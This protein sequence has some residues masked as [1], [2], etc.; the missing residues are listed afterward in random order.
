MSKIA[1]S[2][3]FSPQKHKRRIDWPFR[4][5]LKQF[6]TQISC[7]LGQKRTRFYPTLNFLVKSSQISDHSE[8]DNFCFKLGQDPPGTLCGHFQ[9]NNWQS[10]S[11]FKRVKFKKFIDN[12]SQFSYVTKICIKEDFPPRNFFAKQIFVLLPPKNCPGPKIVSN[13]YCFLPKNCPGP[14]PSKEQVLSFFLCCFP[15]DFKR[16]IVP[17]SIGNFMFMFKFNFLN[18]ANFTL[19]FNPIRIS[20]QFGPIRSFRFNSGFDSVC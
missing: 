19:R 5:T 7:F 2:S 10:Q 11:I 15:V 14:K 16:R 4:S 17:P 6:W 18:R 20:I 12:S 13:L 8:S 1:F 3:V 9:T